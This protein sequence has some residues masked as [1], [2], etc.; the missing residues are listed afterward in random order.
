MQCAAILIIDFKIM[1]VI[2]FGKEHCQAAIKD[3][4]E[5]MKIKQIIKE[6]SL[7]TLTNC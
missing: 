4:I 1:K 7:K 3:L 2:S 5:A 6:C